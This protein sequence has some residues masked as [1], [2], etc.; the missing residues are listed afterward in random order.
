MAAYSVCLFSNL[1]SQ[2]TMH[3]GSHFYEGWLFSCSALV[4]LLWI[5]LDMDAHY[6]S[7]LS[8]TP[9]SFRTQGEKVY[10][11]YSAHFTFYNL[12]RTYCS[13]SCVKG[14]VRKKSPVQARRGDAFRVAP[15][16]FPLS[17]KLVFMFCSRRNAIEWIFFSSC[18]AFVFLLYSLLQK[19]LMYRRPSC[20]K[21]GTIFSFEFLGYV[22]PLV[23]VITKES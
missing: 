15:Y 7:L 16:W 22:A 18:L 3:G 5:E 17:W 11:T 9:I 23:S 12:S 19:S 21:N 10:S 4:C 13:I 8:C 1:F 2:V 20:I 14:Q 6:V